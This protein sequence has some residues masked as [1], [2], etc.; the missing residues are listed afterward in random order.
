MSTKVRPDRH[1]YFASAF[2][3]GDES[4]AHAIERQAVGLLDPSG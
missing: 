3:A 2:H 1:D 4:H